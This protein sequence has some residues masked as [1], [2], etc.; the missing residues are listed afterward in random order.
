MKFA[1]TL[2]V[3][4]LLTGCA[5]L[6]L[7]RNMSSL[8]GSKSTGPELVR[9]TDGSLPRSFQLHDVPH[10]P[11]R[12]SGADCGPD[13]LRMVLNYRGKNVAREWNIPRKLDTVRGSGGGTT[14]RQMQRIAALSY[15]LP[16]FVI[17]DCDLSSLKAA[18]L[19]RWPPVVSYRSGGKSYHAVVAVG[20]D[21]KKN[22]ILVHD[23]NFVRVRRIRYYDLGGISEDSIQR[24]SCLLVL[25]SGSTEESLRSGLEKYV[26]KELTSKLKILPMLPS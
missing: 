23:P 12:Q 6:K 15:H 5:A 24:L 25:P 18:I 3:L 7:P 21:D 26:P 4:I 20:Y 14:F 9:G 13:S 11:Y 10:N 17:R 2:A 16:A 22:T 19:N 8:E 1:T